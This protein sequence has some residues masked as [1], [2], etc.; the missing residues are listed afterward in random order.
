[1]RRKNTLHANENSAPNKCAPS[2]LPL[3]LHRSALG[4]ARSAEDKSPGLDFCQTL[5]HGRPHA[6]A[7][8]SRQNSVRTSIQRN[9]GTDQSGDRLAREADSSS[10][11][12]EPCRQRPPV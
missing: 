3:R 6:G 10:I 2:R 11:V 4:R 1:M 7:A 8:S 5:F 12:W 9:P